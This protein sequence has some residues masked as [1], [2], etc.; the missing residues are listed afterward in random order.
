[1][2]NFFSKLDKE[3]KY[4]GMFGIVAIVAIVF[5]MA[6]GNFESAS[7]AGGIKD[8]AGTIIDVVML[9]VA[10]SALRPKK[11]KNEG[12]TKTFLKEMDKLLKKYA[13]MISFYGVESTK[14]ISEAYRY[15]IANKL[16]CVATNNPGG[17]YKLF[18]IKE[19]MSEVEFSVSAT[20][21]G[22]RHSEVASTIAAKIKDTHS[23]FVSN[24][25]INDVGFIIQFESQLLNETDAVNVIGIIDHILMLYLAE[26]SNTK[27]KS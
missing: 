23:D 24:Y 9:I 1:M 20:V 16:D 17:N 25:V 12:F 8:I 10:I 7:I 5:E 4:A 11:E 21:F 15:N 3:T 6:L 19:G 26:Y 13:P 22:D 14:N 27:I 2:K 18:R